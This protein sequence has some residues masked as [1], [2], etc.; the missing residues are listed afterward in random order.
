MV[1]E[2]DIFCRNEGSSAITS[3]DLAIIFPI[4]NSE[5]VI[6]ER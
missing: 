6:F 5:A 2:K 3:R 4:V 1:E